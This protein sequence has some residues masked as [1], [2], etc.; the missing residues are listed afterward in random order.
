MKCSVRLRFAASLSVGSTAR[1]GTLAPSTLTRTALSAAAWLISWFHVMNIVG[2]SGCP[3]PCGPLATTCRRGVKMCSVTAL[4]RVFPE[5]DRVP[6]GTVTTKSVAFLRRCPDPNSKTSVCVP[7]QRHLPSVDGDI[8]A[9]TCSAS[10]ST[11]LRGTIGWLKLT[12]I[13]SIGPTSPFG[14]MLRIAKGPAST[15]GF[16]PAGAGGNVEGTVAPGRGGGM[17]FSGARNGS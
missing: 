4:S 9:G 3:P 5:I 17:L 16:C 15:A 1:I 2:S 6:A 8:L 7:S 10:A 13:R 11:L 14:V 12:V